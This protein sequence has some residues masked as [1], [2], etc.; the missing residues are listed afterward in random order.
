MTILEVA[1]MLVSALVEVMR[2]SIQVK[3]GHITDEEAVEAYERQAAERAEL[4]ERR[5]VA[6]QGRAQ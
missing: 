2:L 1:Q 4:R 3:N 5:R 6:L